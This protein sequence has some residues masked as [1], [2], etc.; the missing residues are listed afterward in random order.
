MPISN[1]VAPPVIDSSLVRAYAVVSPDVIFTGRQ[2]VFVDGVQVG[3]AARL[4]LAFN[5]RTNDYLL[6]LCNDSWK[7]LAVIRFPSSEEAI[8]KAE[9][10]YAG[11]GSHWVRTR[12]SPEEDRRHLEEYFDGEKCS[13]CD[14]LPN[15]IES[16]FQGDSAWICNRCV[17]ELNGLL[18]ESGHIIND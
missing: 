6:L 1:D 11:I 10:Y 4:A 13:F 7:S 12:F 14:A 2:C 16:M 3:P 18:D 5:E 9:S 8:E 15:K 17:V